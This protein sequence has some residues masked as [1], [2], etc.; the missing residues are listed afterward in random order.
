MATPHRQD[1]SPQGTRQG[2]LRARRDMPRPLGTHK[3]A[4]RWEA[5]YHLVPGCGY[6]ISLSTCA[7]SVASE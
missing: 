1:H 5:G 3:K 6:A 7:K 4:S 2:R